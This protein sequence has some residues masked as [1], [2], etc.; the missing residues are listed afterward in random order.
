MKKT[1]LKTGSLLLV[2]LIVINTTIS[3]GT[4]YSGISVD[5]GSKAYAKPERRAD[6][7]FVI[8]TTG[9]MGGE[10]NNVKQNIK[11][12][13][14][15]LSDNNIN[16]R[17]GL[18][19]YKDIYSDGY[20]ST[21]NLGWFTDV[22]NFKNTLGGINVGGG[23]D[24]PESAVDG[25]EEARRMDYQ[26]FSKKFII[27][28]T[29]VDYKEGTR[30]D[31]SSNRISMN[32]E[33]SLLKNDNIVTSVVTNTAYHSNYYNLYTSTNGMFTDIQTAFS[34]NLEELTNMINTNSVPTVSILSPG[35]NQIFGQSGTEL[36]PKISV[37]DPDGDTLICNYYIDD[38]STPYD[39]K[40][41]SN[42]VT[43]QTVAFNALEF[44]GLSEG[45]HTLKFEITDNWADPI[46]KTID[47]YIDKSPPVIGNITASSSDTTINVEGTAT[48]SGAGLATSP[49]RYTIDSDVSSW[50]SNSHTIINLKPNTAY[51]V[52]VEARDKL[53]HIAA[54]QQT[55]YTQA[56]KPTVTVPKSTESTVSI[57]LNDNNPATT[58]YQI[59]VGTQYVSET[60][61]LTTTPNWIKTVNKQ[62]RVNG[63]T[64][65]TGYDIQAVAKNQEGTP[66]SWSSMVI[67]TTTATPPTNITTSETQ[68]SIT[69]NWSA[70]NGA[71]RYDIETDGVVINNGSATSYT[72]SDLN[73]NTQHTYRVRVKNA[74]GIGNWSNALTILTL[75]NPPKTPTNISATA[76]Q[77]EITI[78]WD[79]IAN[80]DIYDVEVDG[81]IIFTGSDTTYVQTQLKPDSEHTYRVRAKNRGGAS[82]WS[83]AIVVTTLPYPPPIPQS[84]TTQITK[85]SVKLNWDEAERATGYEIEVD[86][87][88]ADNGTEITYLHN[89]LEPLSGH[90]YRVRAKN[91]GGKSPWSAPIDITT[92]PEEPDLP[93]NIMTTA[94]EDEITVTWYK[95]PHA[96]SYEVEVDGLSVMTVTEPQII[97]QGLQPDSTHSYRVRAKNISGYSEWSSP[98]TMRTFPKGDGTTALTNVIAIVTNTDIT[99]SW[100]TVAPNAQ[101]EIEV[102]G[103]L[104]DNGTET[105]YHHGGLGP[106]EYHSYRIRLKN[107]TGSG[108]WVAVLS[109]AT[110]PNPPDAP[111]NI[112]AY[113]MNNSIELRWERV[114]G[115][116]GYE[117]E[118]DGET[119][120]LGNNET[121]V[122]DSLTPGTSHNYRVRAKNVTG[123]TAWSPAITT[124]TTSPTYSVNVKKDE[125]FDFSLLASNVQDYSELTFVVTYN[126]D[127]VELVDLNNFTPEKD[128]LSDGQIPGTNLNVVYTPGRIE[129]KVN[130]NIVPGTSWS[131]EITT[132]EFT[133]K[134][135]GETKLDFVV[136]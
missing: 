39:S 36:V 9:S 6:I 11:Q 98:V 76:E 84:I 122:H 44:D 35:Q 48:D 50:T 110:L 97:H 18:V 107:E 7:V 94:G 19:T 56:H 70:T 51:N 128:V 59:K 106:K 29:D 53:E 16:A 63:L 14:D 4:F 60:G 24:R 89:G 124:S 126:S 69:V 32:E 15:I 109:L 27:L 108:E 118:V 135:D 105:I 68:T 64:T 119:I 86:G 46:T 78:V 34:S 99:I 5:F 40:T 12:F 133:S 21:K 125:A 25:L 102:D 65:N 103:E 113:A 83:Q 81:E 54:K 87:L 33:I 114:E 77:T 82:E 23:G 67:G 71:I 88:I 75:P 74:G 30:F 61:D 104:M 49:Y 17:L 3:S 79:S 37:S 28:V 115:A 55:I 47:I 22:D 112:E 117:I 92:Y 111:N 72:H 8:D 129:F 62:I 73:P 10:I 96:E 1:L 38:K 130:Q 123:V 120:E 26:E 134:V 127:E 91:L 80:A 101:Y 45:K 42:T 20:N 31:T 136:E 93:N 43:A 121:Y 57:K 85:N 116:T 95:V 52:K 131:G 41:I 13:V 90:T 132:L 2:F 66:T 58:Q 100:D